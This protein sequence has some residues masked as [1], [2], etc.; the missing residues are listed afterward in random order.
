M[1]LHS[2]PDGGASIWPAPQH[3]PGFEPHALGCAT[4]VRQTLDC[5]AAIMP[6]SPLAWLREQRAALERVS[7]LPLAMTGVAACALHALGMSAPQGE[8]LF[9]LLRLPGAAAHALEQ[10]QSGFRSFP[11]YTVEG[12]A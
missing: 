4:I 6:D 9:L 1:R 5:F 10:G 8:M 2:S 12:T 7:G 11:F 3:A